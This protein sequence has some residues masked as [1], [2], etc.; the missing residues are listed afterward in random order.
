MH[1]SWFQRT[2]SIFLI[3]SHF[4]IPKEKWSPLLFPYDFNIIIYQNETEIDWL[5]FNDTTIQCLDEEQT[6]SNFYVRALVFEF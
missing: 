1:V 5:E 4:Y 3:L 2:Y 6:I